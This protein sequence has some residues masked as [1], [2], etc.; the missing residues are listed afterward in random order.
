M[1]R[2]TKHDQRVYGHHEI[3]DETCEPW[4]ELLTLIAYAERNRVSEFAPFRYMTEAERDQ[5]V[6]LPKE[7]T[8]LI[9]LKSLELYG[10]SLVRIPPFIDQLVNLEEFTPYTSYHLHYLPYEITRLRKLKKS[11]IST[12]ALYG[13]YKTRGV[14]PDLKADPYPFPQDI[15]SVCNMAVGFD[16]LTQYWVTLKV[17]TDVVPLLV[18]TCS[19][20]CLNRIPQSPDDYVQ[21]YHQ[22][23]CLIAQPKADYGDD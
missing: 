5:I 15:C 7:L 21:G 17:A 1:F 6:T 13:N 19:A 11:C 9:H 2:S 14:F 16:N 20:A 4:K 22:G 12:R 18:H 8:K 23:G 3:Q 10:T